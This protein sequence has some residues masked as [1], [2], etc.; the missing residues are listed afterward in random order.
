MPS[1]LDFRVSFD[2]LAYII[3]NIP[4][5][6]QGH[7]EKCWLC[8]FSFLLVFWFC[9]DCQIGSRYGLEQVF[10]YG[11]LAVGEKRQACLCCATLN[12]ANAS[13]IT[14]WIV[15]ATPGY[16]PPRCVNFLQHRVFFFDLHSNSSFRKSSGVTIAGQEYPASFTTFTV[17]GKTKRFAMCLQFQVKSTSI[18]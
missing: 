5:R 9:F 7:R 17:L 2:C 8:S 12:V 16:F 14:F 4:L 13:H 6:F 3:P 1:L 11:C 15:P 10:S 18:P